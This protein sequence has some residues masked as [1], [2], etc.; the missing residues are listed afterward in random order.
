MVLIHML[1]ALCNSTTLLQAQELYRSVKKND[2]TLVIAIIDSGI[3]ASVAKEQNVP[4]CSGNYS[5][6]DLT[7][8]GLSDSI[9]H[10][11][12]VA[13]TIHK[14]AGGSNYCQMHVKYFDPSTTS[15]A[16]ANSNKAWVYLS[17][18]PKPPTVINYSS[19]GK[20]YSQVEAIAINQ[21]LLNGV[22]IVVAAGNE[23][24]DLGIQCGVYPACLTGVIPVGSTHFSSNYGTPILAVRPG[25]AIHF[26]SYSVNA[27]S[28]AAAEF[29]GELIKGLS[30]GAK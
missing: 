27:T 12:P 26:G 11:T 21:L 25:E 4:L 10:G 7:G 15:D 5:S 24:Q 8:T 1:L 6:V 19:S 29:S 14:N 20:E 16:L 3:N 28:R 9:G 22:K 17:N 30:K 2:Q 13:L 23:R 18:L